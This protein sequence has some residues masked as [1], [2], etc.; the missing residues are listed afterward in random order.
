[1]DIV[2]LLTNA[3]GGDMQKRQ[4]AQAVLEE[5]EQKQTDQYMVALCNVIANSQNNSQIR[6]I[7]ALQIKNALDARTDR[8]QEVKNARYLSIGN[9]FKE[10]I[11]K[12]LLVALHDVNVPRVR[13]AAA[14]AVAK[15]GSIEIPQNLWPDLL[16]T[17]AGSARS[18]QIQDAVKT[19]VL[20][21]IGYL[22]EQLEEDAVQP[23]AVNDILTA[24]IHSMRPEA[25]GNVR[26]AATTALDQSLAFTGSNMA[27]EQEA[28]MIVTQICMA[29]QCGMDPKTWTPLPNAGEVEEEVRKAAFE[30]MVRLASFFYSNLKNYVQTFFQMTVNAI[31]K[32]AD[33]VQLQAI[34]FW[35]TICDEEFDLMEDGNAC[36]NY[37]AGAVQHL[38]P[39]LCNKMCDVNEDDDD[40]EWVPSKAAST[41][42]ELMSKNLRDD[43]LQHVMP[44][45]NSWI[46]DTGDWKKREAAAYA[47]GALM[48]GSSLEKMA[49]IVKQAIIPLMKLATTDQSPKVRDT[50]L[51]TIA[52]ICE[53]KFAALD[54]SCYDNLFETILK[55]LPQSPS[56]A[57]HAILA[58][59]HIGLS[60]MDYSG[61]NTN[62]LTKYY[63]HVLTGL[64]NIASSNDLENINL[65]LEAHEAI[66]TW[67][68]A[69]ATDTL[70]LLHHVTL[71]V[72]NRLKQT[73]QMP[74]GPVKAGKLESLTGSM[75]NILQKVGEQ[76]ASVCDQVVEAWMAVFQQ[77]HPVAEAE[78]FI[79]FSA[80]ANCAEANFVRY[81]QVIEPHLLKALS[82]AENYHVCCMAIGLVGD[83]SRAIGQ[84]LTSN[85][86]CDKIMEA[87][88]K[89]LRNENLD[90]SV[91][92][93]VLGAFGDIGF[94][95]GKNVNRYLAPIMNMM[96]EASQA[97]YEQ[98]T[99]EDTIEFF[100][101]MRESI[102]DAYS[103]ILQ[104]LTD[105][106]G[107]PQ[108]F[109]PYVP[110]IFAFFK[111]IAHDANSSVKC[112][113][114]VSSLIGDIIC[115]FPNQT[116]QVAQQD[117]TLVQLVNYVFKKCQ[118]NGNSL[119]DTEK[120]S[121][122]YGMD[123]WRSLSQ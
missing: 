5:A 30:C 84:Q 120:E 49:P 115:F 53:C 70:P 86:L 91:K 7:A 32:D 19:S 92:P 63:Q 46:G 79:L 34:E 119:D 107:T 6:E 76:G 123:Q 118:D 112:F 35:S 93:P 29:A 106:D 31:T 21:C 59:Y 74:S 121:V 51:W 44:I 117:Q 24:I 42:I 50:S 9:D 97:T 72:I 4:Q 108:P 57:S 89:L 62:L 27:V 88:L 2:S 75:T 41:C 80:I 99:D 67:I 11:K 23:A 3:M 37:I 102:L 13:R 73:L 38:V 14:Q 52:R 114:N 12:P 36:E 54:Q 1:M 104:G 69:G 39:L 83:I 110:S 109:L 48:E 103:S 68:A 101:E 28:N 96:T 66:N 40:D 55:L 20:E 95:I 47:F 113:V 33:K 100:M 81:M 90:R 82:D 94:G 111:L 45:V 58:L 78:C 15:I 87:L 65:R 16:G 64:L 25:P 26:L 17:L 43:M 61:N 77:S 60:Q 71:E 105:E 18:D 10:Q 56:L 122:Q 85:G 98:D 116:K 22:C 8:G